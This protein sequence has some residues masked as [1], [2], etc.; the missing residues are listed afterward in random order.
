MNLLKDVSDV[1]FIG[2]RKFQDPSFKYIYP[3]KGMLNDAKDSVIDVKTNTPMLVE[4]AHK[5]RDEPVLGREPSSQPSVLELS[6][7]NNAPTLSDTFSQL[8][9]LLQVSQSLLLHKIGMTW[10]QDT[11]SLLRYLIKR[12]PRMI[13][14]I[15]S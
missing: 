1:L 2:V 5:L 4:M 3:K 6:H 10:W 13:L 14:L 7:L 11:F 8:P 15:S 9:L 12:S